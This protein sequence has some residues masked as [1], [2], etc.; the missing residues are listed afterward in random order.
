MHSRSYLRALSTRDDVHEVFLLDESRPALASEV[1]SQ[2]G[3]ETVMTAAE[4]L[5]R[6]DAVII[7]SANA[8]HRRMTIE[9]AQAGVH[10]LAEKPLATSVADAEAM[11]AAC[12]NAGVVLA[13][14]FPCPFSPAFRA[15]C[16]R[17]SQG[18]L[19]RLLA[20]R[21][22]NRGSMPGGFFIELDRSGGGAVIDH[23]VHVADLLRR[24]TGADPVSVYAEI[25]HGLYHESW[26]DSGL[27]TIAMGD[28]SV[29]TLDCSWSRPSSYPTWGDVNLKVIGTKA[30]AEARL[31]DQ[32][33][34][35]YPAQ[36][37]PA[38]WIS[39][40]SDLDALMIDDFIAAVTC[41]HRPMSTGEDGLWALKVALAA[42]ASGGCGAP[43]RL[44]ALGTRSERG[45]GAR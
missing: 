2:L 4:L 8:D 17:Y 14:A 13:T 27:L 39:W 37:A 42:Y 29:A 28:G 26:D 24:L 20:I 23:T 32:H 25:G 33:I 30:T 34:A 38:R 43:I 18:E 16:E 12:N 1:G 44:D 10:V 40:G 9:A 22:T 11:I 45:Q 5:D 21:A 41:S 36:S 35:Y 7:T 15:L 6:V 3:I 19:G 31:F